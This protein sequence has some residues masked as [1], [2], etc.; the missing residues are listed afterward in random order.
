MAN[1]IIGIFD[2]AGEDTELSDS[3][4]FV[5][6]E[7]EIQNTTAEDFEMP[8]PACQ[9]PISPDDTGMYMTVEDEIEQ[10]D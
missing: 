4:V 10:S 3:A 7:F 8:D 9:S 2:Q 5:K 1:G 6:T